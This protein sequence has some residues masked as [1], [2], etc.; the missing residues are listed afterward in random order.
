MNANTARISGA[1][2]PENIS[3]GFITFFLVLLAHAIAYLAHEYAHTCTAWALGWM[4]NPLALDYG[5]ASI[6]NLIFLGEVSDNVNYDPIFSSGHG[7]QASVIALAGAFIGNGLLYFLLYRLARIGRIAGSRMAVS[8]I[9]WLS[10]M[11]A[12]NVWSYVPIRAI[13]THADIALAA[14]GLQIS[15]WLLF[16]FL[17]VPS[18]YIVHHFFRRMFPACYPTMTGGSANNLALA[19]AMTAFWYFSFFGGDGIGGSYGTVSQLLSIASR[20]LLFPLSAMYLASRYQ[21]SDVPGGA[22]RRIGEA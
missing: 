1:I 2:T 16:P 19:I 9:Y 18:L 13:T 3:F 22:A 4:A 20:Y 8:F 11:C 15:T 14:K 7:V 21:V 10:L 6:Y 12:G 5:S 17:I